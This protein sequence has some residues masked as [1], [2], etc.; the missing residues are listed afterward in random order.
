ML[1]LLNE[2][3]IGMR[4]RVLNPHMKK[5]LREQYLRDNSCFVLLQAKTKKVTKTKNTSEVIFY[6][7]IKKIREKEKNHEPYILC[8]RPHGPNKKWSFSHWNK[9]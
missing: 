9:E 7:E 3:V 2:N 8:I 1:L 6:H 5:N 4:R